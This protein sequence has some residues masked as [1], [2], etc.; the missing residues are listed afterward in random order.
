MTD[1]SKKMYCGA[2]IVANVRIE[3][4]DK[5]DLLE[6]YSP[7]IDDYEKIINGCK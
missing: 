7:L 3:R 1:Y 6:I 4:G 5:V 2:K